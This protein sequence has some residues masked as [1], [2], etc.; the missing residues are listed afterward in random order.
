MDKPTLP[1]GNDGREA[2]ASLGGYV[3]QIYQA[4]L[5]WLELDNNEFL[6]LEVA[7]DF[8]VATEQALK[9]VQV[10]RTDNRVTLNSDDIISSINSF[11]EL[12]IKQPQL[13]IR[14]RHLTTSQ[15]GKEKAACDRIDDTPTLVAWRNLSRTGDLSQLRSILANSKL[16]A[17]TKQFIEKF[18]D[19]DFREK[20]LRR[21]HFD[22]GALD[23]KFLKQEL[24]ATVI[25][26]LQE[27]DGIASQAD[28]CISDILIL[29][30]NKSI[31]QTDRFVDRARLEDLLE[32]A[33]RVSVS[34]AQFDAQNAQIARALASSLPKKTDL[35]SNRLAL[36]RPIDEVPLPSAIAQRHEQIGTIVSSLE[37]HGISWVLGAAG[38]GKTVAAKLAARQ[39]GGNWASVNLRGLSSDQV[40]GLL[41]EI[42]AALVEEKEIQ[43]LLVDDFECQL[44]PYVVEN[45][46]SLLAVCRRRDM[47]LIVT[48][49]RSASNDLL[50]ASG[51]TA[52]VEAKLEEFSESDIEQILSLLGVADNNWAKYIYLISGGGHPQ[53]AIAA[54]QSMQ[55]SGWN[56]NE[57]RTFRSLMVGNSEIEQVRAQTRQRLLRDL[58]EGSRRLLERISLAYGGFKRTLVLDLAQVEPVVAD[59]GILFDNLVGSWI[60]Q[61]GKDRFSL[62]PLLS[63]FATRTLTDKQ[64]EQINFEI[65]NSLVKPRSFDPITANSALVAAWI[66]KNEDVILKLCMSI[67]G[68]DNSDLKILAPH[69]MILTHIRT[70][71][72]AY[73]H[74]PAISQ[75]LRGAQLL[76]LCYEESGAET[77]DAALESFKKETGRVQ[78]EKVRASMEFIIYSKLLLSQP[79]FGPVPS[80]L[81]VL[82]KLDAIWENQNEALPDEF[83]SARSQ[84]GDIPTV[85]GFMFLNQVRQ[86][87]K[88]VDL[89]A[90]FRSLDTCAER[91]RG[92]IFQI[93]DGP[94]LPVDIDMFISGAWLR[95]HS[96][97]TIDSASHAS[98]YAQMENLANKWDRKDLAIACRKYQAI[99]LDE[100]GNN[101]ETALGILE[102]GL[103]EYGQTNSEL[104]RA[105]AKVLYRA[106]DHQA[107]LELS[108]KL[109]DEGAP[110]SEAEK[111]F[112]GRE[113]AIS[114]EK[115]GDFEAARRYYLF[116]AAAARG[117]GVPDMNPMHIGLL[118]DAALASWQADDR[119]RCIQDFATVLENLES[120]DAKSSI[121]A[122]HCHAITRH[123]L[124]WL[125]Q[126]TTGE[127][128]Y[129]ANKEIHRLS[130]GLVSNPEPH[131]DIQNR[132]LPVLELA[133][134]MLARIE[135]YCL[136]DVGATR[137]ID[138]HLPNG[139][140]REGLI[141]LTD[142]KMYKAFHMRNVEFFLSTLTDTVAELALYTKRGGKEKVFDLENVTY[143]T[144]PSPSAEEMDTLVTMTEQQILSFAASCILSNDTT[145][146]DR[147]TA[148]IANPD[149]FTIRGELVE[150]LAGGANVTDYYTRYASLLSDGRKALD[151]SSPLSP[152]QVFELAM[153]L[154]ETGKLASKARLLSKLALIWLEKAWGFIWERQRFLLRQP[155][156]Y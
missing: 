110:L 60:D 53:L 113:A 49:P 17:Q 125:E 145:N 80:F 5:A 55:R 107:S 87:K 111:A 140:L 39:A 43:G 42:Q 121:R 3:Y 126:E 127:V 16:S 101:K 86:T 77:F 72:F 11:V 88:I 1:K 64:K 155:L 135:N 6:F 31:Q 147:L 36:P 44:E 59:S 120:L 97:N 45:F 21:I 138:A 103:T 99:I 118:A 106:N 38:V 40:S 128:R 112:L 153:K 32:K 15:I 149:G 35:V 104:I 122:A 150:C 137:G 37:N 85:V 24:K 115:Q 131:P 67:V 78:P 25:K 7:E 142:A 139:P 54:I 83:L 22:C 102:N 30:L 116:G 41:N 58:P 2:I 119:A 132:S 89:L 124:V 20:F 141:L 133:W 114:A 10:K 50:F 18:D 156:L 130:P 144:L 63:D 34:R 146:Y 109:I 100:Y 9:A 26:M 47:L 23:F 14:L 91:F 12:Q 61:Q 13:E 66:G 136:L 123:V 75:M 95:E 98:A 71:R 81:N 82:Q 51:L 84:F 96:A 70:D 93:Y 148:E 94:E 151:Q 79:V 33:T 154:I 8:V 28:G 74:N 29:L 19:G 27:R 129:V 65:A 76:L 92:K 68:S 105:K 69:L 4:A 46:L 62:S 48:A 56:T 57:I 152:T 52:S 90:T 73:E 108:S 134:Y 143:G 117:L